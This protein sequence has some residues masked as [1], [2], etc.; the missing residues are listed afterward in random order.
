VPTFKGNLNILDL[1]NNNFT[2]AYPTD[3]VSVELPI[4]G[5]G[6]YDSGF[7]SM[8]FNGLTNFACQGLHSQRFRWL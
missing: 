1:S 2:G 4:N 5:F 7:S 6:V 8:G 3:F